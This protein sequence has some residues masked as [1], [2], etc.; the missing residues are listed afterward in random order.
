MPGKESQGCA[1]FIEIFYLARCA[2]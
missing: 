2:G 1:R